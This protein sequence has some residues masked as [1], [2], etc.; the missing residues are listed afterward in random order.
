MCSFRPYHFDNFSR[1]SDDFF[2]SI[3]RPLP[4]ARL[5]SQLSFTRM[6]VRLSDRKEVGRDIGIGDSPSE[7]YPS[8]MIV[9]YSASPD[10]LIFLWGDFFDPCGS[11][12]RHHTSIPPRR[13]II[14]SCHDALQRGPLSFPIERMRRR[15]LP[16]SVFRSRGC[17]SG[18]FRLPSS[19]REDAL[20]TTSDFRLPTS[21]FRS[22]GCP[23][24]PLREVVVQTKMCSFQSESSSFLPDRGSLL[25][26]R[27]CS[28][29]DSFRSR[30]G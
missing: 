20:P 4:S 6:N 27:G 29:D 1:S 14:K 11:S 28:S 10:Q 3:G 24:L 18:G 21:D 25:P 7:N 17:D 13:A 2:G 12:F 19:N 9:A 15:R 30:G 8:L 16:T 23:S 26:S 22:R 5:P